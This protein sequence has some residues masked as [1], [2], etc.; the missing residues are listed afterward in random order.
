MSFATLY[1]LMENDLA[2]LPEFPGADDHP[3]IPELAPEPVSKP[4]PVPQKS[5]E[6]SHRDYLD[7]LPP[8]FQNTLTKLSNY[9][10]STGNSLMA[11]R[12]EA[13]EFKN[14]MLGFGY[15]KTPQGKKVIEGLGQIIDGIDDGMIGIKDGFMKIHYGQH[16]DPN[17]LAKGV[18]K[19]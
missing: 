9:A 10:G 11:Y 7:T 6:D 5:A 14:Q 16:S 15:G 3:D 18:K 4:V 2:D 1:L 13:E 17:W 8:S 19:K 12:Q